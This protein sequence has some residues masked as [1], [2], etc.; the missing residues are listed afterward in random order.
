MLVKSLWTENMKA[1]KAVFTICILMIKMQLG[2][3]WKQKPDLQSA[4][5]F[6]VVV[7]LKQQISHIPVEI[8]CRIEVFM[9]DII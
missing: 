8:K 2:I 5:S 7:I 1:Y 9:E 6:R 3:G 4:I